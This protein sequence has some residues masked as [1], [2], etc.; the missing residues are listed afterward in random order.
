MT[1]LRAGQLRN[2]GSIPGAGYLFSSVQATLYGPPGFLQN[3]YQISFPIGKAA[4][5]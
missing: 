5:P 1:R 4:G 2:H 3:G